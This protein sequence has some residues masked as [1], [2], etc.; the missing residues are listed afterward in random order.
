M[1]EP[2]LRVSDVH[3]RYGDTTALDGISLEVAE[4]ELFGLL[5]PNGAGTT[6]LL[7]LLSWLLEP[8]SGAVWIAGQKASTR[9]KHLRSTI[10]IVPQE[11]AIYGE[12]NARENLNFF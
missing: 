6:T 8:T 11:L 5:G 7:S 9:D 3:K 12:L 4:G 10:G 2:L 1:T